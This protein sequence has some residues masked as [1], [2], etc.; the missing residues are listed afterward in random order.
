MTRLRQTNLV[1]TLASGRCRVQRTLLRPGRGPLPRLRALVA[2]ACV[3]VCVACATRFHW[4]GEAL[5]LAGGLKK[6]LEALG[7]IDGSS[8]NTS[9]D[10]RSREWSHRTDERSSTTTPTERYWRLTNWD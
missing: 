8:R 3:V 4:L 2:V 9:D 7:F 6:I 10:M 5:D 1:K